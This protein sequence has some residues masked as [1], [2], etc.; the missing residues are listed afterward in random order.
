MAKIGRYQRPSRVASPGQKAKIAIGIASS[1]RSN[2][3]ARPESVPTASR[4]SVST[5][6]SLSA[7]LGAGPRKGMTASVAGSSSNWTPISTRST[8][9]SPGS[10]VC[11]SCAATGI[12]GDTVCMTSV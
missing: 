4:R 1:T 9:S 10:S 2:A 5:A 12:G 3:G 11:W 7:T 8:L 6:A